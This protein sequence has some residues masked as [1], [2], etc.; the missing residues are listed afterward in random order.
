MDYL[1]S[2]IERGPACPT[3]NASSSIVDRMEDKVYSKV[4]STV[5]A[6]SSLQCPGKRGTTEESRKF[7]FNKS[8]KGD[9]KEGF[10]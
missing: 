8:R 9:T 3:E 2:L 7:F 1:I 5:V 10:T 4:Y 6:L